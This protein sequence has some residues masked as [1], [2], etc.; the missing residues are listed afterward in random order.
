MPKMK[1]R[2]VAQKRFHV[3]GTGK[4]MHLKAGRS[5]LRRRK[6]KRVKRQYDK[7]SSI[8]PADEKRM[9]KLLS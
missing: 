5:H 4:I 2:K 6:P 7:T 9:R 3:T 8:H 1:T